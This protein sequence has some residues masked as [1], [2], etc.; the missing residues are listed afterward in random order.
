MVSSLW[1]AN[2]AGPRL[3]G[4]FNSLQLI[5]NYSPILTF[6][7][8]NGLNREIPY[9]VGKNDIGSA[10]RY[11]STAHY[12]GLA[13]SLV[14]ATILVI[15]GVLNFGYGYYEWGIGILAFALVVPF[16]LMRMFV[17]VTYR[18]GHDFEWLSITKI[19]T[20]IL[21]VVTV[22][23]LYLAI[24][25]GLLFR[26]ILI[27]CAGFY[28][29]WIKRK[30]Q[31]KPK[32]EWSAAKRLVVIGFPIFLVGYIYTG[33]LSLDRIVIVSELGVEALGAYT[34]SILILQGMAVLPISVMQ[35]IY[36][37]A[38]EQYGRTGS[39]RAIMPFLFKPLPFLAILQIPLV[40]GAW[41]LIPDLIARYMPKFTDGIMAARWSVVAGF[42]LT[43]STPAL[44]FNILRKQI[45]YGFI[46]IAAG[47]VLFVAAHFLIAA[48]YGL[49]SV[50]IATAIAFFVFVVGCAFAAF[51]I[52]R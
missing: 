1:C 11:C 49:S 42:I 8:F 37:R 20:S 13:V 43:L 45:P 39:T 14:S 5:V 36:P 32:W 10:Y 34:P 18:T 33:L 4:T 9:A 40:I 46:M 44:A 21:A 3:M 48:G 52:C 6:G 15:T 25:D 30:M 12:F 28:V 41:W 27:A 24:W 26:A 50:A 7:I 19:F 23:L 35:V 51:L 22:P 38:V 29:L 16:S 2:L 17:E 31:T 47:L